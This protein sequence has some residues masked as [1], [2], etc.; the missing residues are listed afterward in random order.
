[1]SA[2]T[3]ARPDRHGRAK[4]RIYRYQRHI[5][6]LTRK[7]YL[8]GRD[9]IIVDL[10]IEADEALLEVGCGTARNLIKAARRYPRARCYGVDISEAMLQTARASISRHRLGERIR[11]ER[12]DASNF[13]GG[14]LFGQ[15]RFE[16]VILSYSLSMIPGWRAALERAANA[17]APGGRLLIIDFGDLSGWPAWCREALHG[18]LARF[19]VTPR[20]EMVEDATALAETRG[21]S[22]TVRDLHRGYARYVILERPHRAPS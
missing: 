16:R 8:F 4:D 22:I 2:A 21:L 19:H 14:A 9:R 7:Y 1:M 18:W 17:L 10:E 15:P 13:D 6:D 20:A 3:G 5:Y 12:A 11:L